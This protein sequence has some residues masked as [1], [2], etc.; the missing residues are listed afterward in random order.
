MR[1]TAAAVARLLET[2]A[3]RGAVIGYSSPGMPTAVSAWGRVVTAGGERKAE[4]ADRFLLT[5]VAK[6]ITATQALILAGEGRLD[7]DDPVSRYVPGAQSEITIRNLVEHTSGL[8]ASANITEGPPTDLGARDMVAIVSRAP[9][10][11]EPGT[12]TRYCSPGFWL[13]AA[14]ITAASG[15]PYAEHLATA[16]TGPLA[17]TATRYEPGSSPADLVLHAASRNGHLADQVRRLEYPAGGIVGTVA[18]LLAWGNCLLGDGTAETGAVVIPTHTTRE[19]WDFDP[20]VLPEG[21]EGERFRLGFQVGGPGTL[22]N[23]RTLWH[24]GAS[25]TAVWLDPGRECAVALLTADWYPDDDLYAVVIDA[26]LEDA[27]QT[28]NLDEG[29]SP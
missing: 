4:P 14:A 15:V 17:M 5:S 21:E 11:W 13:L 1:A 6:P 3:L 20:S 19:L 29:G 2:T 10:D 9:L 28:S 23:E 26:V 27:D 8:P 22:R 24:P 25:G 7:L 12:M 18:D 16:V